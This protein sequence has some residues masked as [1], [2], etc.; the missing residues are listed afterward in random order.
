[1]QLAKIGN[2][3][4]KVGVWLLPSSW[5][6]SDEQLR[7]FGGYPR[8][9]YSLLLRFPKPKAKAYK[10]NDIP[11]SPSTCETTFHTKED[12]YVSEHS[13]NTQPDTILINPYEKL[14]N[15]SSYGLK[16]FHFFFHI[17]PR[18]RGIISRIRSNGQPK[19]NDTG[20]GGLCLC[21]SAEAAVDRWP[22]VM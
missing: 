17:F 22:Y 12:D 16:S 7:R 14:N 10:N 8:G 3:I 1:M 13:H 5:E 20:I 15:G 9:I 4:K 18:L 21:Q 19:G 2:I 11:N 6:A